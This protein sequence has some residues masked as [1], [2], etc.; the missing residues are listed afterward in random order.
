MVEAHEDGGSLPLAST[1]EYFPSTLFGTRRYK[2]VGRV[3][4][5]S[6]STN[7]DFQTIAG[8]HLKALK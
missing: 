7:K 3:V 1:N 4:N 5:G 6:N 2:Q 8:P